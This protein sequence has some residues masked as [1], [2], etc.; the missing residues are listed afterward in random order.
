MMKTCDQTQL[1]KLIV[2]TTHRKSL[3]KINRV[4]VALRWAV[5]KSDF[6]GSEAFVPRGVQG[7]VQGHGSELRSARVV[8][9]AATPSFEEGF[10]TSSHLQTGA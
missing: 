2:N 7:V 4:M 1:N 5:Q 6:Q 9:V 10:V 3:E 8:R